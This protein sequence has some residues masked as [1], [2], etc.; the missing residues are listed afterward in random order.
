MLSKICNIWLSLKIKK[1][2]LCFYN[3]IMQFDLFLGWILNL[4]QKQSTLQIDFL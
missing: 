4:R 2:A 3:A 1:N